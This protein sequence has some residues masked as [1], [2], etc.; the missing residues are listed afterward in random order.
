MTLVNMVLLDLMRRSRIHTSRLKVPKSILPRNTLAVAMGAR[1]RD[2]RESRKIPAQLRS[3]RGARQV[4]RTA[5]PHA[6]YSAAARGMF[7][8]I[9]H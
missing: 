9:P 6:S 7:P 5:A 2:Y 8:L 1:G 3:M 4:Q